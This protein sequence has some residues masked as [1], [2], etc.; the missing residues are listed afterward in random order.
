MAQ[1]T[2]LQSEIA[3]TKSYLTQLNT[4]LTALSTRANTVTGTY[5]GSP[6]LN[7]RIN[8]MGKNIQVFLKE[9]ADIDGSLVS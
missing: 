5:D 1:L 2:S 3:L 6:T 4:A 9:I 7:S 8:T